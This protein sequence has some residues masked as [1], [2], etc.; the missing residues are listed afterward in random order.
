MTD[1]EKLLLDMRNTSEAKKE[2]ENAN[3]YE[4]EEEEKAMVGDGK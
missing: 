3:K 4:L 2:I 1:V